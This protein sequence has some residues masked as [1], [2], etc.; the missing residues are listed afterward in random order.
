MR[1]TVAV[2]AG[3]GVCV[4]P[5]PFTPVQ[6]VLDVIQRRLADAVVLQGRRQ[7]VPTR[8]SV[9]KGRNDRLIRQPC[10]RIST[11]Y[12]SMYQIC[13]AARSHT[14]RCTTSVLLGSI[15]VAFMSH[16][17][18]THPSYWSSLLHSRSNS[19][20][21]HFSSEE[22]L[23]FSA[24]L[25]TSPPTHTNHQPYLSSGRSTSSSARFQ[26]RTLRTRKLPPKLEL[27]LL[28]T[29]MR[30]SGVGP[31]TPPRLPPA[32][33][34]GRSLRRRVRGK[35]EGGECEVKAEGRRCVR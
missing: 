25:S 9:A 8:V 15:L 5:R 13:K 23:I 34:G 22:Y 30:G 2:Q 32:E 16:I 12:N 19:L 11:P 20:M 26:A 10:L 27:L 21:M 35:G 18:L 31:P 3:L 17:L 4:R 1:I 14:L 29:D 33:P 24:F 6:D 7:R 28:A